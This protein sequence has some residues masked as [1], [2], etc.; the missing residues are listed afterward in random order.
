MKE[1]IEQKFWLLKRSWKTD[2]KIQIVC[3]VLGICSVKLNDL[4]AKPGLKLKSPLSLSKIASKV[5]ASKRYPKAV[6]AVLIH[7]INFHQF[8]KSGSWKHLFPALQKSRELTGQLNF[9]YPEYH[10]KS[11]ALLT[12]GIDC[13]HNY[14]HLRMRTFTTGV[15]GVSSIAWK[16][17]ARSNETIFKIPLVEDWIDKQSVQVMTLESV[18]WIELDLY[19][20]WGIY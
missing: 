19:W 14:T 4:K 15:C 16:A 10:E 11:G 5:M 17:C 2:N 12:K 18:R 7:H 3:G 6:C 20:K 8:W 13:S 9:S 1:G